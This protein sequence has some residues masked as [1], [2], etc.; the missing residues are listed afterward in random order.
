MNYRQGIIITA[1]AILAVSGN[2]LAQD[3][4]GAAANDRKSATRHHGPGRGGYPEQLIMR[5]TERLELDE[6]QEQQVRNIMEAAKPTFESLRARSRANRAAF[7]ALDVD[8]PD[9]GAAL[10][11]LSAESGELAAEL[12]LLA[13]GLRA[14]VSAVLNEEQRQMLAEQ[15]AARGERGPRSRRFRPGQ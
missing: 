2:S 5:I 14:D 3:D 4:T 7:L 8:D 11:D 13:G 1:L 15:M 12:T 9:Y 10:Q 6:T